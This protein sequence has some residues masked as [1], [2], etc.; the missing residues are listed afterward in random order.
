M[1]QPKNEFFPFSNRSPGGRPE[2]QAGVNPESAHVPPLD[3]E[4]S[5]AT[6]HFALLQ[7]AERW[8]Q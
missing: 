3:A 2:D 1:Q 6:H 8:M 7:T 4:T 5:R